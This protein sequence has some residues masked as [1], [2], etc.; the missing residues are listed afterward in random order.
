MYNSVCSFYTRH[1]PFAVCL[2]IAS[3]ICGCVSSDIDKPKLD[4][5]VSGANNDTEAIARAQQQIAQQRSQE[6]QPVTSYSQSSVAANRNSEF[7]ASQPAIY[8]LPADESP[9]VKPAYLEQFRSDI[10]N[11]NGQIQTAPFTVDQ[12]AGKTAITTGQRDGE[13]ANADHQDFSA[14]FRM[15]LEVDLEDTPVLEGPSLTGSIAGNDKSV[16]V[17]IKDSGGETVIKRPGDEIILN[18]QLYTISKTD[19]SYALL[20]SS[21]G[22]HVV[23]K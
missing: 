21:N 15:E 10:D 20:R 19:V 17:L 7:E 9:I 11:S 4:A 5:V 22:D 18:G 1:Q 6:S 13:A 8:E 3:A 12:S 14:E 23:I 2:V 16:R